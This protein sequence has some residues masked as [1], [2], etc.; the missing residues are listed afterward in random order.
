MVIVALVTLASFILFN[1]CCAV[2]NLNPVI[3]HSEIPDSVST[4]TDAYNVMKIDSIDA[5]SNN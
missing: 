5:D 4:D 1:K 2:D 3:D